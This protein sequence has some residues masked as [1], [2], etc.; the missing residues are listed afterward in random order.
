MRKKFRPGPGEKKISSRS[1]REKNFG[2]GSGE[3]KFWSRSRSR[4]EKVL[5]LGPGPFRNKFWCRSQSKIFWSWS[6]SEKILVLVPVK[7]RNL[8]PGPLC[9]SLPRL[10]YLYSCGVNLSKTSNPG[11]RIQSAGF[12][13]PLLRISSFNKL[14]LRVNFRGR[15]KP[16][17]RF[18]RIPT[19]GSYRIL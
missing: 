5:G 14:V 15:S 9:P 2:P 3:E 4:R 13:R 8:F 7:K 19:L 17:D 12:D 18:R 10:L 11:Q 16:T 1:W 6:C